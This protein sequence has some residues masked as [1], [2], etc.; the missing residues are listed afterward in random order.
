[1]GDLINWPIVDPLVGYIVY[2]GAALPGHIVGR[3][4][5]ACVDESVVGP[6]TR[7]QVMQS[8]P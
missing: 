1:M 2:F 7:E 6:L 4:K 8:A 5:A 3:V